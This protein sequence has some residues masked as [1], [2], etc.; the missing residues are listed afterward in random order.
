MTKNQLNLFL[1]DDMSKLI[2]KHIYL[3]W[4]NNNFM[5]LHCGYSQHT[6]VFMAMYGQN[7]LVWKNN[8]HNNISK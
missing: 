6:E 2:S 5:I 3:F 7:T 1:I 8:M 4:G